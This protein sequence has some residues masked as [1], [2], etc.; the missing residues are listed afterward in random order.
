MT[1]TTILIKNKI[2]T[3]LQELAKQFTIPEKF[4]DTQTNLV[5][6]ILKSKSLAS[7]KEKQS[8]FDML[9][10]MNTDQI[11]KLKNILTKELEK[12]KEIENKYKE[13]KS[14]LKQKYTNKFNESLYMKKIT[15]L[16]DHENKTREDDIEEADSLLENL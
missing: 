6:L 9:D 2:P 4:L 12:L 15:T 7:K 1:D 11:N 13:K 3:E 5:V 10:I 14:E 8:W 16:K